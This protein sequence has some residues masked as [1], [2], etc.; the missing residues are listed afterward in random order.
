M[1]YNADDVKLTI[2]G[3]DVE[4]FADD[5]AMVFTTLKINGKVFSIKMYPEDLEYIKENH[6]DNN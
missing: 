3:G 1:M 2:N 6:C 5:Y 4:S